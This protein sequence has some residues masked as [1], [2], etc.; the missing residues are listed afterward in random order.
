MLAMIG[1]KIYR[2]RWLLSRRLVQIFILLGFVVTYPVV[3]KLAIGNLSSSVWFDA[4]TLTDP[5]I[6]LQSLLAGSSI[7][8]PALIGVAITGGFYIV[9]GGRI[10]CSWVCP[11]NLVTD[12][13]HWL[14]Q[15]LHI[16]DNLS[17]SKKLRTTV[18]I[19]ALALSLL[20]GT[21]AWEIINPITLLQR[22]IMWTSFAGSL[23][24]LSIFLF[25]LLIS[26]RGWCGHIC[27]VGA[28][29][30]FIGRYGRLR[31]T[32]TEPGSCKGSACSACVK[33]CPEPHVLAPLVMDKD[34]SVRSG[35]CIRCGACLDACTSGVVKMKFHMK[36]DKAFKRIPITI[37]RTDSVAKVEAQARLKAAAERVKAN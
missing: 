19:A 31:I 10:Y 26:R 21:L 2:H 20:G 33:A 29:Y 9:F 15:K 5:F 25:D 27:P 3:G 34:V 17:I 13:A 22:E 4:I 8:L 16:K 24:L 11:I 7:A 28:F 30:A 23:I 32:A 6:F 12:A 18:L 36:N 14:K 1:K 35:D 37:E